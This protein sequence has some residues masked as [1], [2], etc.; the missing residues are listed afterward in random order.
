MPIELS[1]IP[2]TF[3]IVSGMLQKAIFICENLI[4]NSG[5]MLENLKLL[6]G[7][8]LSEIVA[9]ALALRGLGH[10]TQFRSRPSSN[11]CRFIRN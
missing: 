10:Y 3:I 9:T 1:V 8:N 2:S 5:R 4:V 7:L 6:K 11:S